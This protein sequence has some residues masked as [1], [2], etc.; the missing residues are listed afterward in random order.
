MKHLPGLGKLKVHKKY[1]D[2]YWFEPGFGDSK[3]KDVNHYVGLR[4]IDTETLERVI[5]WM[6]PEYDAVM[7]RKPS[8]FLRYVFDSELEEYIRIALDLCYK[9]LA[10]RADKI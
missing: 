2:R 7:N 5:Q 6:A 1:P 3:R 10:R 9:E 8:P 4:Y